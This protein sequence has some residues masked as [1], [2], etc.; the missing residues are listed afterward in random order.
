MPVEQSWLVPN[1]VILQ[2]FY[3]KVTVEEINQSSSEHI[4][5]VQAGIPLVHTIIDTTAI[6]LHPGIAELK[7]DLAIERA[8][9]EGWRIIISTEGTTRFAASFAMQM[10]DQRHRL[11]DTLDDALE[12]LQEQDETIDLTPV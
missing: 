3:D 4:A 11:F 2:Q 5:L 6:E 1:R 7:Q 12:F 8:D 9:N 10:I